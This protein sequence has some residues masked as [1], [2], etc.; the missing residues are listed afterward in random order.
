M[1]RV[2]VVLLLT[3]GL[4]GNVFADSDPRECAAT[5]DKFRKLGQT[6]KFLDE[7]YGYA[8]FPTIG[9]GGIGIGGGYGKGCVFVNGN[10]T[11]ETSMT[12]LSIGFQLGGQA[13]SQIVAFQN[14]DAY[15]TFISGS[16][17]FGADASAIALTSSAQ[18]E[19]GTTG[20][21]SSAGET[22]GAAKWYRGM[23]VFVLGK[24]GLMFEASV[25]GQ[26]F[27]FFPPKSES[28]AE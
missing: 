28:E 17:E 10:Q 1:N 25:G 21:Q 4:V 18:A 19:T 12:Q 16:F 9:K 5:L 23:I 6:Q 2:L 14:K 24:G 11:G 26:K 3:L 27:K 7:A 22:K 15:N 13:Y 20:S 8:I